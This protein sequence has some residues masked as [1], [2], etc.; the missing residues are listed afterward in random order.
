MGG[1]APRGVPERELDGVAFAHSE[2]GS[3]DTAA[4]RPV[5]IGGAF[6]EQSVELIAILDDAQP[7]QR[8]S[9]VPG[10]GTKVPIWILGSSLYG[11][12]LAAALGLPYAFASHFAPAAMMHS[13]RASRGK[14]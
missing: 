7:G 4:E 1:D 2:Q 13:Q 8:V 11:A 9:A 6:G 10:V 14:G 12:Q 3:R 5:L